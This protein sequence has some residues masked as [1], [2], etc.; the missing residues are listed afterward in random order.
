M[1]RD[2]RWKRRLVRKASPSP[3]NMRVGSSFSRLSGNTPAVKG[4]YRYVLLESASAG[5]RPGPRSAGAQPWARASPERDRM[6]P[7]AHLATADLR[8]VLVFRILPPNGGPGIE[9]IRERASSAA[10]CLSMSGSRTLSSAPDCRN[11]PFAVSSAARSRASSPAP[12]RD[13]GSPARTPLC[14]RDSGCAAR[15]R[16]RS[17]WRLPETFDSAFASRPGASLSPF[18]WSRAARSW[19]SAVTPLSL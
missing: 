19:Y 5:S 17:G 1:S 11:M 13:G 18:A 12:R 10:F 6:Q 15:A 2:R 4:N 9:Q 14:R 8:H 7:G 16:R 3:A